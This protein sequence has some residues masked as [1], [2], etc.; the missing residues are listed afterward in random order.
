MDDRE[1]HTVTGQTGTQFFK[2]ESLILKLAYGICVDPGPYL[3][4]EP[5]QDMAHDFCRR[6]MATVACTPALKAIIETKYKSS[7]TTINHISF[8]GGSIDFVG[9]GS[10]D[11]SARTIRTVLFDEVDKYPLSAGQE[12][13]P[14]RLG[15]ER[16]ST[17][18]AIGRSKSIRMCSP[19][20]EGAS[21]IGREYLAS[22][23]RRLFLPCPHCGVRQLL[24]WDNVHWDKDELGGGLAATSAIHCVACG[25]IWSEGDRIAALDQLEHMSD[26]GWRQTKDFHCC[27]ITQ[28]PSEWDDQGRSLCSECGN[29]SHYSGHAGFHLSKL[30][31]K[32][33]RL[34]DIVQEFLDAEGD[35][36]ALS[37]W[38]N[39]AL[40]ELW[41]PEYSR[42]FD[43]NRLMARAE[44]YGPMDLP[45][46]QIK[47]ITGAGDVH[48]D[49]IEILLVAWGDNEEC[50]PF[51]Y[52]ILTGDPEAQDIWRELD[53]LRASEFRV[54]GVSDGVMR[55]S[56]FAL[57]A[58]GANTAAVLRYAND[59]RNQA[60]FACR[61]V[62]G[63]TAGTGHIWPGRFSKSKITGRHDRYYQVSV[64]QAKHA[65]YGRL[66]FDPPEHGQPKPGFIHFPISP[67]FGPEFFAQLDAERPIRHKRHGHEKIIWEKIRQRNEALDTFVLNL[68]LRQAIRR[69]IK[70]PLMYRPSEPFTRPLPAP[71]LPG[72]VVSEDLKAAP[73][74]EGYWEERTRRQMEIEEKVA[75]ENRS[76]FLDPH[77]ERVKGDFWKKEE[78]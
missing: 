48:P 66:A 51:Q 73:V 63:N 6:F 18:K 44:P 55:I 13:S 39:T 59:R 15:E 29:R 74:K 45:Q 69:H 60:V 2:S 58:G 5:T 25:S 33:H 22:D 35:P 43:A 52:T 47:V 37:K 20:V 76:R 10:S 38:R 72:G 31:S 50:W 3:V 9:A 23:Q 11:L 42:A 77:G 68:A 32:R 36:E 65:I 75:A 7:D 64:D 14:L 61:G 62:A 12:G 17:Y 4:V 16:L 24:I 1:T 67:E 56:A 27:G 70:H 78:E 26:Y 21:L 30:Y 19:T 8:P 40:A 54:R 49:R 28:T 41:K 53:E 46:N 57:N 71:P 34:Q